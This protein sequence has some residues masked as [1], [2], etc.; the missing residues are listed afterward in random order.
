MFRK[1]TA[2]SAGLH[3]AVHDPGHRL[4]WRAALT[5]SAGAAVYLAGNVFYL[6]RLGVH[7][8]RWLAIM[9]AVCLAV[10][11]VGHAAGGLAQVAVLTA[12]LLAALWPS[13]RDC[14]TTRSDNRSA[15]PV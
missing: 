13:V 10:A 14:R 12:V 5:M 6:G 3:V 7:G 2:M 9:A 15:E 4:A 1:A 11:P 8:R